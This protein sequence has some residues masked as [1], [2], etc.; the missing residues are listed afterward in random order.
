MGGHKKYSGYRSFAYLDEGLDFKGYK[1]AKEIGRV[2]PYII[3]LSKSE[4]ERCEGIID[5]CI[6]ISLHDHTL[7]TPDDM[8]QI[9]EYIR[10]GRLFTGYEGLSVSGLDAVFENFLDGLGGIASKM[11][12]KWDDVVY[13]L[14]MKLSDIAHQ[15]LVIRGEK[16]EDLIKAHETGKI[17]LIPTL[18][19][20]TPIENEVDRVDVLYGLGIRCMGIVYSESN[21]L[22]SGLREKRD[23]GLTTFGYEV[24]K[25]M[26]KLGMA[27]DVSHA[28]DQT[29]LDVIEAS[30]KPI[31]ITHSGA[32]K[33]W[34]IKRLEPDEVLVALAEKE[35]VI[36]IEA[37][38]HTT[39]TEKHPEHNIES[40]MEHFEYCAELMGIDHV[41]FGPDT[42]FGDH[43]ALHH[44]FSQ[45]LSIQQAFRG[46]KVKEV[47]YVKGLENPSEFSNIV[48]WLVKHGYSD[49]EIEK[50]IGGNVLRILRKVWWH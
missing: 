30:S 15:D 47:E 48:R 4:E 39:I 7:V 43:V 38:P 36:G 44:I 46:K 1:L 42:L 25:R 29:S 45:Q 18:E 20:A 5:K 16:V 37:S 6:V 34:D 41:G 3:H 32:R 40:V 24:V 35:G 8:N 2:E 13:D 31:F 19:S 26:N 21:A 10:D 17:A 28:G 27:I 9:F 23:G 50:V 22:G 11:G 12:W 14:G 33:L 49:Q